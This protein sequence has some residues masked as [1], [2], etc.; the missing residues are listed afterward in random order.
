MT[1]FSPAARVLISVLLVHFCVP[2]DVFNFNYTYSLRIPP[3]LSLIPRDLIYVLRYIT[4]GLVWKTSGV[5]YS[6]L[7]IYPFT[8]IKWFIFINCLAD[9]N[10]NPLAK[11]TLLI[12]I[13]LFK[14]KMAYCL[15]WIDWKNDLIDLIK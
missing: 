5:D 8:V 9:I 2:L 7:L 11:C 14:G 6:S 3:V 13:W 4:F 12:P 10:D 1:L 15:V